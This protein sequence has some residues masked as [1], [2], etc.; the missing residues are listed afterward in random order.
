MEIDP[1]P[2]KQRCEGILSATGSAGADVGSRVRVNK[3][4][5]FNYSYK[6]EAFIKKK[7][8]TFL[9]LGLTPPYFPESVTKIQKKIRL[10]K[11]NIKPF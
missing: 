8:V 6:R 1:D 2:E 3:N 9:H 11:C 10:L 7:S 4:M 5:K